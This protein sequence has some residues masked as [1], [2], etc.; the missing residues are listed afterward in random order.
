MR[1]LKGKIAAV[2]GGASGIGEAV[3]RRL[4]EEGAAVAILDRNLQGAERVAESLRCGG[5]KAIAVG[6]DVGNETEVEAA[7]EKV[8]KEYGCLD[9]LVSNAGRYIA[10]RDTK[11]EALDLATWDE[12]NRANYTGM[13]LACKHGIRTIKATA[14]KGSVVCT[15]SP[16]GMLGVTPTSTAY[17]SSKGGVHGLMRIM[18]VDYA[19]DGIR[20]NAVVPGFTITPIVKELAADPEWL[21]FTTRSIPMRR[22]AQPEEIAAAIAFVASDDASYMTGSFVIVDGGLTAV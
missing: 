8:V 22:G 2:T 7:F 13:F 9:I 4:T 17:S 19:L 16:T 21:A 14:K 20:V 1:G 18:A 15:G 5:V 6:V 12:V 10:E 11:I 3:A